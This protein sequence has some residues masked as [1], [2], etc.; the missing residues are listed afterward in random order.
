MKYFQDL[1]T[2]TPANNIY[3]PPKPSPLS[4]VYIAP[5]PS[6]K[7]L[8]HEKLFPEKAISPSLRTKDILSHT[9]TW[10]SSIVS[11]PV[12][13]TRV[14]RYPKGKSR[15]R[16]TGKDQEGTEGKSGRSGQ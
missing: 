16:S 15:P 13:Y 4:K 1:S 2:S 11:S 9:P 10:L 5:F 7:K 8:F 6:N 3:S 12:P 14:P